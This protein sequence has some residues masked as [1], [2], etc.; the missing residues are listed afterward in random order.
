M[1]QGCVYLQNAVQIIGSKEE[2]SEEK[3]KSTDDENLI[4]SVNIEEMIIPELRNTV[5]CGSEI[6]I[7]SSV[8]AI[9][10]DEAD[11]D[12][13]RLR[14]YRKI[15]QELDEDEE[16]RNAKEVKLK[17]SEELEFSSDDE[18]KSRFSPYE[19]KN[20]A[21]EETYMHNANIN[22]EESRK[23]DWTT[24]TLP[25][26]HTD[27]LDDR[28]HLYSGSSCLGFQAEVAAEAKAASINFWAA[29]KQPE[30]TFGG[31]GEGEIFG[32]DTDT[33]DEKSEDEK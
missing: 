14:T 29:K 6:P 3:H 12:E 18:E 24:F 16:L 32:T 17:A 7:Q 25:T 23:I 21:E 13:E 10:E 5:T 4:E 1:I 11:S 28:L 8:A 31:T 15:K 26:R 33:E 19:E 27:T 20:K 22:D 9:V 30:E 2:L